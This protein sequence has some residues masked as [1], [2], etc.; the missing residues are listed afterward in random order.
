[1]TARL[2]APRSSHLVAI[3]AVAAIAH[4]SQTRADRYEATV[5]VRP[6]A[7]IAQLN[8]RIGTDGGGLLAATVPGGGLQ[9][10]LSYG[11]H[12]YLDIGL[13]LAGATSGIATYDPAT[14]TIAEQPN[15]GR[16]TRRTMAVAQLRVGATLRLGVAWVP[17]IY[18]GVGG[19]TRLRKAATL[20][21]TSQGVPI[22]ETPDGLDASSS[23]DLVAVTRVGL[24][25]RLTRRWSFGAAIGASRVVGIGT[26]DAATLEG[27]I[28]LAYTWYP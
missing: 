9:L 13:E 27:G 7:S 28:D 25:H 15:T 5:S 20:V 19:G 16:V 26:T 18:L 23:L 2:I 14:V 22:N 4:A 8:E 11:V 12:N 10:G 24:S 6:V 17:T 21:E 3:S 1:M